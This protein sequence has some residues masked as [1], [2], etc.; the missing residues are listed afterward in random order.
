MFDVLFKPLIPWNKNLP[1]HRGGQREPVAGL[2][3]GGQEETKLIQKQNE[4]NS[5]TYDYLCGRIPRC[6]ATMKV[7][8]RPA[9]LLKAGIWGFVRDV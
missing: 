9:S 1:P 5:K 3:G 8:R 2:W 6:L 4:N 7:S